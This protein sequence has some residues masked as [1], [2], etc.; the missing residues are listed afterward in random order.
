M[1]ILSLFV[2]LS[3]LKKVCFRVIFTALELTSLIEIVFVILRLK[4]LAAVADDLSL[5][6]FITEHLI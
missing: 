6:H 5:A 1:Q 2:R 4:L 3:A